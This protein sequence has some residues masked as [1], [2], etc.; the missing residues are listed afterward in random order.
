M[1]PF[2][3]TIAA[4]GAQLCIFGGK[5]GV[6]SIHKG[7]EVPIGGVALCRASARETE[8]KQRGNCWMWC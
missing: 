4:R 7:P 2:Q 3:V 1:L 8:K 6:F 5:K